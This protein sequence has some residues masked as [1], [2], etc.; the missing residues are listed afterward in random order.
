M[1]RNTDFS[2]MSERRVEF[3]EFNASSFILVGMG[4]GATEWTI[5]K[6]SSLIQDHDGEELCE[7][8][9]HSTKSSFPKASASLK[10]HHQTVFVISR[11]LV[12]GGSYPSAE[13]QSVYSTASSDWARE[14]IYRHI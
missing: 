8:Q 1:S 14:I 13:V 9:T 4:G 6:Q 10:L 7:K 11:A 12:G 5:T 2:A 3:E